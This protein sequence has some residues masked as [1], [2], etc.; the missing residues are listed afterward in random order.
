MRNSR[1]MQHRLTVQKKE[2]PKISSI[3][4]VEKIDQVVVIVY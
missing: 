1:K 2:D 3:L 4:V